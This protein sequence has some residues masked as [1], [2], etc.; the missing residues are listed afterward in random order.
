M[1]FGAVWVIAIAWCFLQGSITLGNLILGVFLGIFVFLIS[2][3]FNGMKGSFNQLKAIIRL[4]LFIL[5]ELVVSS[6]R[7]AWDI[8]TP[9]VYARPR[10]VRIP[11]ADLDDVATTVLANAISLTPGSLALEVSENNQY[12]YVHVMYAEDRD[13]A[14]S[15]IYYELGNRVRAACGISEL[16]K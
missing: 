16:K 5:A 11:I 10:I 13:T 4:I 9:T 1:A 15:D 7:V 6:L 2:L 8:L 3:S 12:L 14:V